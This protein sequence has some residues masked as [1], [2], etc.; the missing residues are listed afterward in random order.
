L[1]QAAKQKGSSDNISV[2]VVFFREPEL[3][4]RRPL[5]PAPTS[6]LEDNTPSMEQQQEEYE[7]LA[8][9]WGWSEPQGGAVFSD[10]T[11]WQNQQQSD[12]DQ[13]QNP[14][15]SSG[16]NPFGNG[17]QDELVPE[18]H[19][20]NHHYYQGVDS[21]S[22]FDAANWQQHGEEAIVDS[23]N[24]DSAET[25]EVYD[26]STAQWG[27]KDPEIEA[28]EIEAGRDSSDHQLPHHFAA[29]S[30]VPLPDPD[31]DLDVARDQYEKVAAKWGRELEQFDADVVTLESKSVS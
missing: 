9:K 12:G 21:P 7:K 16:S 22:E 15:D 20:D 14:F 31:I 6:V 25:P 13:P 8:A 4:A 11:S 30:V 1:V 28:L 10:E 27:W 24:G 26:G 18:G 5:P 19:G 2:I 29:T 3:I 17:G 23:F